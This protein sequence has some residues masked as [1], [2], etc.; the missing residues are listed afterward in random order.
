MF[1]M[2]A[3]TPA[4]PHCTGKCSS[5]TEMMKSSFN[6]AKAMP[7]TAAG[8]PG[9]RVSARRAG[10]SAVAVFLACS[11]IFA[12]AATAAVGNDDDPP[13]NGGNLLQTA[14]TEG[15]AWRLRGQIS[16]LY[17]NNILRSPD[18][19]GAVR[20]SPVANFNAGLP[21][22]RQQLFFG[23]EYGRD[24]VFTQ[25]RLNRGRNAIGGGVEWRVGRACSG[26]IG[27]E[28]FERLS[29]VTEQAEL[30]NNV[31]TG[32][33]LAGSIGCRTPTGIG[34]GGSAQ[35]RTMSND[36]DVRAPFD[37]NITIFAPNLS[38][39][40]P[41]L[42]QFSV[43]T[44]FNSTRYPNRQLVTADGIVDDGIR[45]FSGRFG[46]QRGF[47]SRLQLSVGASY[48]KSSPQPATQLA[49]VDNQVVS[50]PRG[51]FSGSGF[52]VSLDYTPSTRLA[53]SLLARRNV[54]VSPNV[55]ALFVLRTDFGG[56]VS[57]R[58]NPS[59]SFNLGALLSK[60]DYKQ[61]FSS[62]SETARTSD[63]TKRVYAGFD[64]SPVKLYTLQLQVAHQLRRSDPADFNFD[65]T[66]VRLNLIV[67]FGRG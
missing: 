24:I 62:P 67:N 23:V 31:Q 64:Y 18:P 3:A 21:V 57:Y 51:G 14:V 28:R 48:L 5:R 47:G 6:F 38:Y 30:L 43:T 44:T 54:Q 65:S 61:S 15:R 36:L 59:M 25:E 19:D 41:T 32:V 60:S 56:D 22:G 20:L 49:I 17:D 8:R 27:A 42:G 1:P 58:M 37:L 33:V 63:N 12:G 26:V 9:R 29:V 55:G 66:S 2:G 45:I 4:L 16:S 11:G 46:Y 10:A 7:S 13:V 53:M 35:R 40:T 52:D 34:F 39:G 50:V